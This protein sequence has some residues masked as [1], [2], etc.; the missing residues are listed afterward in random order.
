MYDQGVVQCVPN[1]VVS[2]LL[3][4]LFV[5]DS[6]FWAITSGNKLGNRFRFPFRAISGGQY[7]ANIIP[8][9]KSLG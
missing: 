3:R 1:K 9:E 7:H 5:D 8:I 2:Y 6:I 4:E